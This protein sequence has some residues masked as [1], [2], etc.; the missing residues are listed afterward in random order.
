MALIVPVKINK[1]SDLSNARFVAGMG[2][3]AVGFKIKSDDLE[4]SAKNF[5][6]I[7]LWLSGVEFVL[8]FDQV[9]DKD[10]INQLTQELD[11]NTIEIPISS[12]QKLQSGLNNDLK[13]ILSVQPD[14]VIKVEQSENLCLHFKQVDL[15]FA[16]EKANAFSMFTFEENIKIEKIIDFASNH[17]FKY[18][19]FESG[20]ETAPG[21]PDFGI[22]PEILEALEDQA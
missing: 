3:S 4:F 11:C 9:A 12:Y 22:L 5:K 2:V 7:M 8:E 6:S 16:K 21:M 15:E 13:V 19:C 14:D 18:I 20:T 17:S 1:V 10:Y